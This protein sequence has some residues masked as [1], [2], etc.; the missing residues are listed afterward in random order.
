[1]SRVLDRLSQL[2]VLK[3]RPGEYAEQLKGARPEHVLPWLCEEGALEGGLSVALDVRPDEALGALCAA[4]G[5]QAL[6]L[7]VEDVR[8]RPE[9][10][11][12]VRLTGG[13][14]ERWGVADV[15]GLIHNLNDL[16]R[17]DP[18]ARVVVDLGDREDAQQLWCVSKELLPGLLRE[19]FF[20]PENERQLRDLLA[21]REE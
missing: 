5:G 13:R 18:A 8:D 1:V 19:R 7:R 2:G 11:L 6:Q 12:V 17:E 14:T 16:L 9:P 10:E 4:I 3:G 21:N 20:A 15:R